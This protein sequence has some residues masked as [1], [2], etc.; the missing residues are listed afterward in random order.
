MS[1]TLVVHYAE[2]GLKG[3]NRAWFE[4]RLMALEDVGIAAA[5]KRMPG[6]LAIDLPDGVDAAA[7]V[8]RLAKVPGVASV[9][10]GVAVPRTL[11]AMT[12]A[13]IEMLRAAPPG[14]FKLE[15][16]RGDKTFPLDTIAIARAA[17]A[18]SVEATGRRVDVNH[19][20]VT[21]HL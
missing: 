5:V 3:K 12:E 9:S 1:S 17:G 14:S 4:R 19:P 10:A 11:E 16:R 2:V 15:V 6:R 13:S 7:A 8:A 18:A 21:V 20:D